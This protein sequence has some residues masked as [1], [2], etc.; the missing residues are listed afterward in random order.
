MKKRKFLIGMLI[1]LLTSACG[2]QGQDFDTMVDNLLDGS[3]AIVYPDSLYQLKLVQEDIII[4]DAREKE[5]FDVSH[6]EGAIWVGYKDFDMSKLKLNKDQDIFVY[7]SVGYRSEKIGEKLQD[8]GFERV[9][10]LYGGIFGWKNNGFPVFDNAH[11][12][13]E[14]VH[15]YNKS[16]GKWLTNGEKVYE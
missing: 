16:W 14:Q 13:T 15:T 9:N 5:E 3:V 4:L 6:I 12:E 11:H 1:I 7:C 10:N 8:A 2:L